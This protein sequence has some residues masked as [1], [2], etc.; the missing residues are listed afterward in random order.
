K[1]GRWDPVTDT[2]LKKDF[3]KWVGQHVGLNYETFTSSVLLLQGR[4]E[5]LLDSTAKGRAEVLASIVDLERYQKLH[6]KA[7]GRRKELRGR[8]EVLQ[9]QWDHIPEVTDFELTVAANRIEDTTDALTK[10]QHEVDRLQGLEFQARQW[11]EAQRKLA[12]AGE[13]RRGAGKVVQEAAA[14]DRDLARL[15]LLRDVMPHVETIFLNRT[16][17]AQSEEATKLLAAS[18]RE[19]D[20]RLGQRE[21]ELES[22]R[23]RKAQLQKRVA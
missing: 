22:A 6:E 20:D 11:A 4:A 19:L 1:A 7:D 3:D 9:T 8:V 5:K 10:A 21:H 16:N 17:L 23:L 14:I 15:R 2:H 18:A 12:A 13:R